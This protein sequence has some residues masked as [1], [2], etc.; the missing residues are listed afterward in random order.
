MEEKY[1]TI[2][3]NKRINGKNKDEV[4][5]LKYLQKELSVFSAQHV[6][7]SFKKGIISCQ[8]SFYGDSLKHMP[9]IVKKIDNEYYILPLDEDV[10]NI[11]DFKVE[12]IPHF[13]I[14]EEI[15]NEEIIK[16]IKSM[17]SDNL[18]WFSYRESVK[19]L[20]R[21][22]NNYQ[23]FCDELNLDTNSFTRSRNNRNK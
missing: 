23:K 14:F 5:S 10:E 6:Y 21:I 22:I 17:K 16:R 3:L 15:S 11:N 2:A 9:V 8:D 7:A 1:Y 13:Y 18:S 20:V 12:I 19:E 4:T